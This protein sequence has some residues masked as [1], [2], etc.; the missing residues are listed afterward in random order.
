MHKRERKKVLKKPLG[1][2]K[3][4]DKMVKWYQSRSGIL[5]LAGKIYR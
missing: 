5:L 3:R 4:E 1:E 2:K